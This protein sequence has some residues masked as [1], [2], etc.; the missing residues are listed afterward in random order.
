MNNN[1]DKL[2]GINIKNKDETYRKT[3]VNKV[4]DDEKLIRTFQAKANFLYLFLVSAKDSL[5]ECYFD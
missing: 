1:F 3:I 4:S 2:L 5:V